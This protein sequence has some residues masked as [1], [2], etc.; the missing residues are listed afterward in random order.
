MFRLSARQW[1]L[2]SALVVLGVLTQVA[3]ILLR[4]EPPRHQ[5]PAPPPAQPP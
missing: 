4:P 1:L 5:H 2:L 3:W